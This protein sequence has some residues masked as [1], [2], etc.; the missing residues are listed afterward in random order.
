[1]RPGQSEEEAR[2]RE[3]AIDVVLAAGYEGASVEA[4]LERSGLGRAAFGRHFGDLHEVVMAAY[5]HETNDF[6]ERLHS[7]YRQGSDWRSSLR[8]AAYAAA[9]YI[10]DNPRVVRF[11]TIMLF[12]AGAMAQAEREQHL[13]QM[14]ALIDAG[15]QELEDPDALDR[16]VAEGVFGS[17]YEAV[18]R[19]QQRE[20]GTGSAV[21]MVP[22][23]MYIAVRPYLGREAA[24]EELAIAPPGRLPGGDDG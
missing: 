10:R 9:F 5:W 2:L 15:R 6:N 8:G 17:I 3:A 16:G 22:E 7:A 12:Q 18:I 13:H 11:G 21:E 23:L 4:I 19:A 20:G 24:R 14:V 1:M